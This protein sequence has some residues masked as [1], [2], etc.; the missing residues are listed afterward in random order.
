MSN[1]INPWH[2]CTFFRSSRECQIRVLKYNLNESATFAQE[3]LV[4]HCNIDL[5]YGYQGPL[6][7]LSSIAL[8]FVRLMDE[9]KAKTI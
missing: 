5:K 3:S 9:L 4:C 7:F 6:G 8:D 1:S 2:K